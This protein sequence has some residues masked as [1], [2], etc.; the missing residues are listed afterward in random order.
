AV[1]V[2]EFAQHHADVQ[3]LFGVEA[4]PGAQQQAVPG[5]LL[6]REGGADAVVAGGAEGFLLVAQPE[7]GLPGGG[8]VLELG[9]AAGGLHVVAKVVHL[10]GV[11][12]SPENT[13]A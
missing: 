7:I 8:A 6:R 2:F 1:V 3:G 4:L 10:R 13:Q 5:T 9:A 12:I 11:Q